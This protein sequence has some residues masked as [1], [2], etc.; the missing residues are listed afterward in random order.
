MVY[1]ILDIF[2]T[3]VST[4]GRVTHIDFVYKKYLPSNCLYMS[5]TCPD[6][7]S[8]ESDLVKP[9]GLLTESWS[10]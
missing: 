4:W 5:F 10:M 9:V 8:K 1:S 3:V 6:I 2:T 7:S